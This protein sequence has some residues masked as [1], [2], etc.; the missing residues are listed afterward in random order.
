MAPRGGSFNVETFD[1]GW[2]RIEREI[3]AIAEISVDVG[4][5]GEDGE[6]AR[7]AAIHEFGSQEWTITSKQAYFM[8][9]RLMQIDP[10]DE[11]ARF[12]GTFRSLRGRRMRIPERSFIRAAVDENEANIREAMRRSFDRVAAG[13][14]TADEQAAR[15]GMF[16]QALIQGFATDLSDPPNAPLTRF[17]KQSENPLVDTGRMIGSIRY[18]VRRGRRS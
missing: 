11:P 3:R 1:G 12:W 7:I 2:G 8:A 9:R 10:E 18:I 14:A 4:I 5:Q 15:F 17:V 13:E 6:L 16:V